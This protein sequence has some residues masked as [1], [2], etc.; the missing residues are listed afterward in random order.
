MRSDIHRPSVIKP[1]DYQFICVQYLWTKDIDEALFNKQE[2][3]AWEK[4]RE[5][6]GAKFS[7]HEHGGTCYCCGAHARFVARYYHE[8]TNCYIDLGEVCANKLEMGEPDSFKKLRKQISDIRKRAAGKAKAQLVLSELGLSEVWE[9]FIDESPMKYREEFILCDMVANL[10]K[11]G[12][13]SEKQVKLV[14]NLLDTLKNRDAIEAKRAE[15][16]KSAADCPE[17]KQSIEG[18]VVS[19]KKHYSPYGDEWKITVKHDSGFLVWGSLPK[20]L[21]S[22]ERGYRV[23]FNATVTRSPNDSKFGFFK[24]PTKAEIVSQSFNE[25]RS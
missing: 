22:I 1:E 21:S 3:E 10:V 25:E 24:R 8:A 20:N 14:H 12:D 16:K 2:R 9:L 4:H 15:E 5:E 13:L 18:T 19:L 11:Y 17:G 7:G 23:R 6:T